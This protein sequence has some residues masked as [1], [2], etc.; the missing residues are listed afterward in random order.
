M[1]AWFLAADPAEATCPIDECSR[2][3]G[4][5]CDHHCRRDTA[6]TDR[7]VYLTTLPARTPED[8]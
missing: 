5:L 2:P 4:E 7:V 6:I 3:P 1:A 8:P